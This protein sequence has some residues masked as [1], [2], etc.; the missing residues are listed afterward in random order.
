MA[1]ENRLI[2]IFGEL[3][4]LPVAG[5]TRKG[6]L[7]KVSSLGKEAMNSH[8]FML[9]LFDLESETLTEAVCSSTDEQFD[10]FTNADS[11]AGEVKESTFID[12]DLLKEGSLIEAYDLGADGQGIANPEIARKYNLQSALCFPLR[13][14]GILIGYISHFSSNNTPFTEEEKQLLDIFSHRAS[15]A[16]ERY[17]DKTRLRTLTDVML[18]ISEA[19]SENDLLH[20]LLESSVALVNKSVKGV[21]SRLDYATGDLRVLEVSDGTTLN[22]KIRMGAGLSGKALQDEEPI[23]A[24]DVHADEWKHIFVEGFSKTRSELAVPIIIDNAQ[25]LVG[26]EVKLGSKPIGV[27]NLESPIPGAF[28]EDDEERIWSLARYAGLMIEKLDYDVKLNGLRQIESKIANEDD[29]DK[30]IDIIIRGITKIVG[31]EYV[32]ISLVMPPEYN[33]IATKYVVGINKHE[34]DIFKN[35]SKHSLESNDI[36]AHIVRFRQVEVPEQNDSRFDQEIYKRFGQHRFIR[37]Y[38]P[39]VESS[40]DRVI[41][42]VEAGYQRYYRKFIYETDVQMLKSFVDYATQALERRKVGLL[43]EVAHEF[44]SPIVAIKTT[45]SVISR[46]F[47]QLHKDLILRKLGDILTDCEILLYQVGELEYI[48]GL[49]PQRPKIEETFIFRDVLQK[50]LKQLK[51]IIEDLGFRT[52]AIIYVGNR[53]EAVYTDKAKLNQVFFNLF[54]NSIKYSESD[55]QEFTIRINVIG[56]KDQCEIRFQ[57]WGIGIKSEHMENVFEKGFRSPEAIA[58]NVTGSGLGLTLSREII[59]QLGGNLELVKNSKP[60]EFRLYLPRKIKEIDNDSLR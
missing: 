7:K 59:R 51:P 35:L 9:T 5:E 20:L 50:M 48:L 29:Y 52:D 17:D 49:P 55:S 47:E 12:Y 32:N 54:I 36:Q 45:A 3:S 42:T 30:V 33:Q 53:H 28:T 19:K 13:A 27:L 58:K 25:V 57:D 41:G 37:V 21:V 8:T 22:K 46:R 44:K 2:K 40:T 10:V 34:V 14:G 6:T 56:S 15:Q 23:R 26:T 38:L 31:F 1:Q 39:M 24:D 11:F 18:K 60:T 43:D 16:V 4:E